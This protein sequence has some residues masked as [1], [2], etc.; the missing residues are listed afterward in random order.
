MIVESRWQ[1]YLDLIASSVAQYD[2]CSGE[3]CDCHG[4]TIDKDLGVW[5][6]RGGIE[7]A[8]FEQAKTRGVH[9]QIVNHT[10]YREEQ[11]MFPSR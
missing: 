2:G 3:R 11:C 5:R 1:E 6:E 7:R 4:E 10:L 9:Y 8:E